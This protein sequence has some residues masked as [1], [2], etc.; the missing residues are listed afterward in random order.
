MN[1]GATGRELD[2]LVDLIARLNT[3]QTG[4]MLNLLEEQYVRQKRYENE[5]RAN[6]RYI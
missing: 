2:Q 3:Q 6:K 5:R 4:M 1:L